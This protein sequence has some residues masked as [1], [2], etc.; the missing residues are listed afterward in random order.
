MDELG[1]FENGQPKMWLSQLLTGL[2]YLH[3]MD[4]FHGAICPR[5]IICNPVKAVLVNFGVG[6]D[7]AAESYHK[8]YAD[9]DLWA[10]ESELEKDLYGLIASFID[11]FSPVLVHGSQTKESIFQRLDAMDSTVVG[12]RLHDVCCQVLN[13]EFTPALD[14]SYLGQFGLEKPA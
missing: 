11:V 9:P 12:A 13:F 4:I 1:S 10:E 14:T 6:L 7:I 5:N 8:Q 2:Q 3:R